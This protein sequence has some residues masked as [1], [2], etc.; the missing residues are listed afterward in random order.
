MFEFFVVHAR[1]RLPG[2]EFALS[3][4]KGV[5]LPWIAIQLERIAQFVN[6][7][8]TFIGDAGS[9][10]LGVGQLPVGCTQNPRLAV[11]AVCDSIQ[12]NVAADSP[13]APKSQTLSTIRR[14]RDNPC[15]LVQR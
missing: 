14:T 6:Y 13:T 3:P 8:L 1:L 15:E 7:P 12:R 5:S 4:H 9:E 11:E 10:H 2:R